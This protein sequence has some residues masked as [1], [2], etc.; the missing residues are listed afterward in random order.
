MPFA[1]NVA[2]I[3]QQRQVLNKAAGMAFAMASHPGI[4]IRTAAISSAVSNFWTGRVSVASTQQ[5]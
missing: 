3:R 1:H 2:N 4:C 5:A